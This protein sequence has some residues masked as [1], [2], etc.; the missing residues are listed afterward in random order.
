M[1]SAAHPASL[2]A[3]REALGACRRH[4][5]YACAF[6]AAIN[7][8]YLAP[9]IY[10]L[11]VYDRVV[12]TRGGVTLGFLTLLLLASLLALSLLELVRSRILVRASTR[13]ERQL[14]G[15]IL[16]ASLHAAG[17][18]ASVQAMREFD[19]LR[20]TL[21][22]AGML[23]L[24][25]I[26]WT[27]VYVLLCFALHPLLGAMAVV[28]SV[29]LV[30]LTL[31]NEKV[32]RPRLEA[33]NLAAARGYA[34]QAQSMAQSDV[35]RALGMRDA[36]VQWHKDGRAQANE[37]QLQASFAAGGFMSASKFV[38]L[39]LQSLALGLAAYLV[40]EQKISAGAIFAASLLIARALSPV[41]QVLGSWR[42][43]AET[44]SA[45]FELKSLLS[46]GPG[47]AER[48][49]LPAPSGA[50][51]A[52]QLVVLGGPGRA[53]RLKGVSFELNSG[54]VMGL[55]GPS[56]AGK[57]TL[58]RA[59]VGAQRVDQGVVRL[60]GADIRAWDPDR[61]GQYIGYMPQELGLFPGTIKQNIC[62]FADRLAPS[63]ELDH[64]AVAA[65]VAS[66]AHEMILKL[67]QGYDT[68]IDWGGRGVSLGQ[69]QRIALAR[70]FFG[71][72]K[73][74][75]L[76]E[77]NSHLD[78]EG[79]AALLICLRAL[80]A[81]GAAVILVSHRAS[82]IEAM[83]KALVLVDGQ[84]VQYG[85]RETVFRA[86]GEPPKPISWTPTR[87]VA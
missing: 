33:A 37:L 24:F 52:E 66:G 83:D 11:Q 79:E 63:E 31:A 45:Y 16:R 70:A 48:T 54:E 68:L 18:G 42:S 41:E 59:L 69:A 35:I 6:S 58:M 21:T 10:M 30:A 74:L 75:V 17:S 64:Q 22:G 55:V 39:A 49:A 14:A 20:Q 4:W 9:T 34:A 43:L 36:I 44:H 5:G 86:G 25:D 23:A 53:P 12:P 47:S 15:P 26:P 40:I 72:P 73:L 8:L 65:A 62:R 13:L 85:P 71:E 60:D 81:R 1:S 51:R 87:E 19:T 27:P 67:P 82:L 32:I 28:G 77:P 7:L 2:G 80:K 61:L 76:D 46:A 78:V 3:L 50:L 57:S 29:T 38:R 84:V 56:G